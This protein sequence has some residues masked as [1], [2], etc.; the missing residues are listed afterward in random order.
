MTEKADCGHPVGCLDR[1]NAQLA[2]EGYG[3]DPLCNRSDEVLGKCGYHRV[4]E[5]DEHGQCA[6]CELLV[7]M[8]RRQNRPIQGPGDTEPLTPWQRTLKKWEG[9]CPESGALRMG[10]AEFEQY[11]RSVNHET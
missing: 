3:M 5:E 9:W 11:K 4:E 7:V 10:T 6:L 8:M 2:E 1:L